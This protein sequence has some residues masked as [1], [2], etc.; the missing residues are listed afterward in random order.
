MIQEIRGTFTLDNGT[1]VQFSITPADPEVPW[2][3]WGATRD[4][5]GKTVE[6]VDAMAETVRMTMDEA[7]K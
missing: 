5:L 4:E 2:Q 1:V 6:V 3:Q 7:Q